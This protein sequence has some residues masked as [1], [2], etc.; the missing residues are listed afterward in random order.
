[1]TISLLLSGAGG[2][3]TLLNYR[4]IIS[5]I[6]DK[7]K[8]I[9]R[10]FS[11]IPFLSLILCVFAFLLAPENGVYCYLLPAIVDPGTWMLVTIPKLIFNGLK[12]N[13]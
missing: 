7:R 11:C 12:K 3:F 4:G 9:Y 1:M 6:I 8:G 2:L 5:A 13:N 10:N